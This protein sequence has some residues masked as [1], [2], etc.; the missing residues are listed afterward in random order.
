MDFTHM[1][2]EFVLERAT[3]DVHT[4][5]FENLLKSTHD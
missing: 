4:S 5:K 1:G 3:R 2:Y